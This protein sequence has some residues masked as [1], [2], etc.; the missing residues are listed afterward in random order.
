MSSF[1]Q[2]G[3]HGFLCGPDDFAGA[4]HLAQCEIYPEKRL[5]SAQDK[6]QK[7]RK[8]VKNGFKMSLRGTI[9]RTI[10]PKGRLILPQNFREAIASPQDP[11]SSA[12][13]LG[14]SPQ[15]FI[16]TTFDGCLVAFSLNDWARLEKKFK[17]LSNRSMRVRRLELLVMG[18][19]EEMTP[20]AQGR[21][22]L[23]P[24]HRE[25]AGLER[26]AVMIGM[27]DRF[28][29]W[30]PARYRAATAPESIAGAT[31]ELAA[32]GLDFPL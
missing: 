4:A 2:G 21:I 6:E 31:E 9:T 30:N 18:G 17:N 15:S 13:A 14:L 24:Y 7:W 5:D 8:V 19:A 25:Y 11:A 3:S 12:P 10:D 20:D 23:T 27:L 16:L 28:E 22:L 26:E 1:K 32:S 29:I